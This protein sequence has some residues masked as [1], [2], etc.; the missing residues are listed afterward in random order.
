MRD[1]TEVLGFFA[2]RLSAPF[3]VPTSE[4]T[5]LIRPGPTSKSTFLIPGGRLPN[6]GPYTC[7]AKVQSKVGKGVLGRWDWGCGNPNPYRAR[8]KCSGPRV[9]AVFP[10]R[11]VAAAAFPLY[12]RQGL[13][14]REVISLPLTPCD[15]RRILPSLF[16]LQR[17]VVRSQL[18]RKENPD[19]GGCRRST[20]VTS[21]R[22]SLER[23]NQRRLS[24]LQH[25]TVANRTG[26]VPVLFPVSGNAV[27]SA[28]PDLLSC[29]LL[30]ERVSTSRT[31]VDH[32]IDL[33]LR[34]QSIETPPHEVTISEVATATDEN[35]HD[36][37][38]LS[39]QGTQMLPN[40][41]PPMPRMIFP[42]R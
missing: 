36:D 9:F 17:L 34:V 39:W 19:P 16:A 8:A 24:E 4:S 26:S 13:A 28:F 18:L 32:Q 23:Q 38:S 6:D 30:C 29:P 37:F 27:R 40:L 14:W 25:Q 20:H 21:S 15:Q 31:T 12:E 10:G 2:L 1:N 33:F 5:L 41:G 42:H 22:A 35:S 3:L 11:N 7:G